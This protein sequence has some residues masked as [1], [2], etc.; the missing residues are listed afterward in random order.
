MRNELC[1][2]ARSSG[3]KFGMLIVTEF[4]FSLLFSFFFM[5]FITSKKEEN[6]SLQLCQL[7]GI[8]PWF[9]EIPLT[10]VQDKC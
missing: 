3:F 5:E 7:Q 6:S 8:S 10:I 1:L 4:G 2:P 9:G